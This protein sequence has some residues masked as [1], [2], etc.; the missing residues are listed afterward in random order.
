MAENR[1]SARRGERQTIR[2]HAGDG[3]LYTGAARSVFTDPRVNSG[4]GVRTYEV[5]GT[6]AAAPQIQP[7]ETEPARKTP[8][9]QRK[10]PAAP[11]RRARTA[12]PA[13]W[14]RKES[15]KRNFKRDLYLFGAGALVTILAMASILLGLSANYNSVAN[16]IAKVRE[17][18]EQCRQ[19]NEALKTQIELMFSK[20]EVEAYAENTLHMVK[21]TVFNT[22]S[23]TLSGDRISA[24]PGS[25][26]KSPQIEQLPEAF[27]EAPEA[28]PVPVQ[29]ADGSYIV[30]PISVETPSAEG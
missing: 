14:L 3:R 21:S 12:S 24:A 29:A 30:L 1:N 20:R 28:D 2:Y 17:E 23:I 7:I 19:E 4:A 16:R 27:G 10:T 22:V 13:E 9:P 18:T 15:A 25:A 26:A 8:A 6:A 11:H 5:R